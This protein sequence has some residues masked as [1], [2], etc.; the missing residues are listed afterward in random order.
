MTHGT[1]PLALFETGRT[2]FAFHRT[3]PAFDLYS[4][5]F[6]SA[7]IDGGSALLLRYLQAAPQP[8]GGRV[9]DLGSGHG[10]LGIVLAG[11]N[12]EA[13]ATFTDRDALACA[14]TRH[15]VALNG[16][17]DR[18]RV[19]ASLGYD[20]LEPADRYDLIVA[21]LPGKA[22]LVVLDDLVAHAATRSV[23]GGMLG[24]VV[25]LPLAADIVA[26]VA[27]TGAETLE[28]RSNKSYHVV[29]ARFPAGPRQPIGADSG[30]A[31]FDRGVYDRT[32]AAFAVGRN[33]WT[34]TTVAGI[35]EFDSLNLAT[36]LLDR[37]AGRLQPQPTVVVEPGQGHR[38]L[39][40]GRHGH[41][42]R[43]VTSRDLLALRASRRLLDHSGLGRGTTAVVEH[44]VAVPDDTLDAV[45]LL[46]IHAGERSHLAWLRA[47]IGR[48][49]D[50]SGRRSLLLTG[51][52]S[53]LGRIEAE[54]LRRRPGRVVEVVS[55]R[56][57]R[58]LAYQ[59]GG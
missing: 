50:R 45:T 22:G 49:L 55:Q 12:P 52:A 26:A 1:A 25:V 7:G 48:H 44:A 42:I 27:D 13:H 11:L 2:S 19:V 10:V 14:A 35:D 23:P 21:N 32:T 36:E 24:L 15:N 43:S 4:T 38:A 46:A 6:S 18:S 41:H 5:V 39:L 9:L 59:Q 16:L 40:V 51:R 37:V 3:R 30:V 29:V 8:P 28:E 56:N 47:E 58:A 57:Y 31:A 54:L 17:D 33:R 53:V 34:A 20:E